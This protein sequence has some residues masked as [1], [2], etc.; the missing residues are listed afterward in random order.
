LIEAVRSIDTRDKARHG[1]DFESGMV[2]GWKDV[3]EGMRRGERVE[4]VE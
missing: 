4:V 3:L 1:E 2:R